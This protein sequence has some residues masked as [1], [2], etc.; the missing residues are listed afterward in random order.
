MLKSSLRFALVFFLSAVLLAAQ[1]TNRQTQIA[2]TSGQSLTFPNTVRG[3]SSMTAAYKVQGNPSTL[4]ITVSGQLADGSVQALDTYS[5]PLSTSRTISLGSVTYS[6]FFVTASWSGGQGVSVTETLTVTGLGLTPTP[7]GQPTFTISYATDPTGLS[8]S[9]NFRANYG[10]NDYYCASGVFAKTNTAVP[11]SKTVVGTDSSGRIVDASSVTLG[12]NT[13]GQANTA[14]NLTNAPVSPIVQSSNHLSCPTCLTG[15]DIDVVGGIIGA[16]QGANALG[17]G[18]YL[19]LSSSSIS[20]SS[21]MSAPFDFWLDKFT[22]S[23]ATNT[24]NGCPIQAGLGA[25]YSGSTS[26]VPVQQSIWSFPLSNP[27]SGVYH[28]L[29]P[30]TFVSAYLP[31]SFMIGVLG[32]CGLSMGGMSAEI[33]GTKSQLLVANLGGSTILSSATNYTGFSMSSTPGTSS[34]ES[35]FEVVIPFPGGATARNLCVYSIE[36]NPPLGGDVAFTLRQGVGAAGAMGPTSVAVDVPNSSVANGIYCDYY[37]YT[38]DQATLARGDRIAIQIINN[39]ASTS[40]KFAGISLELVPTGSATGMIIFGSN[41]VTFPN[42]SSTYGAPF[43][44]KQSTNETIARAGMPR[45]VVMKNAFCYVTSAPGTNPY[46]LTWYQNGSA[47]NGGL[48]ISIPTNVTAPGELSDTANAINFSALDT[49]S[50]Q[51]AGTAGG[52]APAISSCSVEVD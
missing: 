31:I 50:L 36:T 1:Q 27:S 26:L 4:T 30:P 52:T 45:A 28:S 35:K 11:A 29:L 34:D 19:G 21:Q 2:Q 42:T 9:A 14:L 25:I 48:A 6:Y 47:P 41:A 13:T 8:C 15:L 24:Q 44:N 3:I 20:T 39:N 18:K 33:R 43:T 5:T 16:N 7:T 46:S 10:G 32:N 40:Q 38:G 49:F 12:N 17:A 22:I 51:Y 37:L 23:T